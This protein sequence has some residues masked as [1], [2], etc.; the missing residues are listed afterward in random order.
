[1]GGPASAGPA[2]LGRGACSRGVAGGLG[3]WGPWVAGE[4][5]VL[6]GDWSPRV[7]GVTGRPPLLGL[8]GG[9]G[10]VPAGRLV[11]SLRPRVLWG[12]SADMAEG[13]VRDAP[14]GSPHSRG[15]PLWLPSPVLSSAWCDVGRRS[16]ASGLS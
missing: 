7:V 8:L 3:S 13:G 5:V 1:M 12:W 15:L 10:V 11:E 9:C 6:G 2:M 16:V 14:G 4:G